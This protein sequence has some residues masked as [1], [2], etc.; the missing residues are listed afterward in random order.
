[1]PVNTG[2]H[3]TL[4]VISPKTKNITIYNSMGFYRNQ[5]VGET[6]LKF[7]KQEVGASLVEDEWT[8]DAKGVSP[9]QRNSDDCG[10]FSITTARQIMLGEMEKEPYT[11]DI[12]PVQRKR[13]V[14]EL[15]NGGLLSTAASQSDGTE[16]Q[17]EN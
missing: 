16:K 9:Q 12:I 5:F 8:I 1:M 2:N 4:A 15:V 7:M 6:I 13:I 3:W 10:V 11:P 17:N 14:A